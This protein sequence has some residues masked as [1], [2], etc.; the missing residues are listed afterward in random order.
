MINDRQ[1]SIVNMT[2]QMSL[3]I[4]SKLSFFQTHMLSANVRIWTSKDSIEQWLSLS[5]PRQNNVHY[6]FRPRR[7]YRQFLPNLCKLY[8]SNFIVRMLYKQ[9]YWSFYYFYIVFDAFC[10][11]FLINEYGWMDDAVFIGALSIN[12]CVDR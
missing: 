8:D 7:H 1:K 9:S 10:H 2:Q 3:I 5:P 4:S 11:H 12:T 6:D